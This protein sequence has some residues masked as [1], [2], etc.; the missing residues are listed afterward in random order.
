M[1]E[2]QGDRSVILPMAPAGGSW[3]WLP[4]RGSPRLTRPTGSWTTPGVSLATGLGIAPLRLVLSKNRAGYPSSPARVW[5]QA[6]LPLQHINVEARQHPLPELVPSNS[7]QNCLFV[8]PY[9]GLC[10]I[11]SRES[12]DQG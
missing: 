10:E 8:V 1:L 9:C 3:R 5:D 11:R 6:R 4:G 7:G 2:V 12:E